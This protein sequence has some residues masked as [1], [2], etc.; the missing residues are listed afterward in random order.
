LIEE[1]IGRTVLAEGV[2]EELLLVLPL[3]IAVTTGAADGD[4]LKI[5]CHCCAVG[6]EC[7]P[8]FP[9]EIDPREIVEA[10]LCEVLAPPSID[11]HRC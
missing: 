1:G 9:P 5:F 4:E 2:E 6:L 8:A 3:L 10:G 7:T 11:V